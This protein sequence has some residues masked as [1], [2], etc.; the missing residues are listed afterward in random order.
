METEIL[1]FEDLKFYQKPKN[2]QF[3]FAL[4]QVE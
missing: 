1:D 4:P 2:T 3:L